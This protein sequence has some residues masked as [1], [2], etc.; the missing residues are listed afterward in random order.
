MNFKGIFDLIMFAGIGG[1]IMV[2]GGL[3]GLYM[4]FEA[5]KAAG[6][7]L[8]CPDPWRVAVYG[9]LPGVAIAAVQWLAKQTKKPDQ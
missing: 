2:I 7:F 5:N 9:A 4:G 6:C 1:P 8:N 3:V